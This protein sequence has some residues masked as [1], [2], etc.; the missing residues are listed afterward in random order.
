MHFVDECDINIKAGNGGKG[1]V[2]WRREA[3]VPLGG[4]YGGNGGN[5]GDIILF[6]DSN[7]NTLFDLSGK[8]SIVAPNGEDGRTAKESGKNGENKVI[9]L[10]LGSTVIDV[11]TNEVIVEILHHGQTYTICNGGKGG[12]GNAFF[13]SSINRAPTLHENGEL[14]EQKIVKIRLKYIADIGLVGLPN[15]GKSTLISNIS[16]AHSKVGDYP[17]T[18]ITPILGV[19][20]RKK[21]RAVFADLPGLIEGATSGKGLGLEFLKHIERCSI[22]VHMIAINPHETDSIVQ[23]YNTINHELQSYQHNVGNKE[24]FVVINKIDLQYDQKQIDQLSKLVHKKIYL[25]SAKTKEGVDDLLDDIFKSYSAYKNKVTLEN[26][27]IKVVELKK[28]KEYDKTITLKQVNEKSWQVFGEYLQYWTNRIPL[29]T[30]DNIIRYNQKLETINFNEVVKQLGAK[31]GDNLYV[32][33]QT[34]TVDE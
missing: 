12:W 10:P 20:E 8:K 13:K 17:F 15:A 27:Q 31:V 33:G 30:K 11:V 5:G 24:T 23:A 4:P 9:H 16:S 18:T 25:I 6:G 29:D 19:V 1:I 32:Y 22:L 21:E 28:K 2:S 34:F 26:K 3:N 14:G 7:I